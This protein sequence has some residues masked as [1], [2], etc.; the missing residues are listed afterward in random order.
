M[1]KIVDEYCEGLKNVLGNNLISII[2]Y[3]SA[4]KEEQIPKESDVNLMIILRECSLEKFSTAEKIISLGEKKG[5]INPVFWSEDEL[6]NSADVFPVEFLDIKEKYRVLHG[7]DIFAEIAIDTKNL[8][9]QLEFELRSKLLH[10]RTEWLNLKGS[11]GLLFYFLTRA[12][13]SF[14]HLFKHAQKISN[15]KLDNSLAQDF[16]T[17]IKLKK[18][19]IKMGTKELENLYEQV[20]DSLTRIISAID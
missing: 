11:K 7:K 3:G 20:H 15:G 17:C 9:H 10:L 4:A 5:N 2:L 8:R 14:L 1:N 6:R 16:Q 19:E 18:K 13:T 12:G